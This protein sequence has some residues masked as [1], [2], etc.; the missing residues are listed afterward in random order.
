MSSYKKLY[1]SQYIEILDVTPPKFFKNTNHLYTGIKEPSPIFKLVKD[2]LL[3]QQIT[4]VQTVSKHRLA[5]PRITIINRLLLKPVSWLLSVRSHPE[6]IIPRRRS[7]RF[8]VYTERPP[9]PPWNFDS[10]EQEDREQV[11][12]THLRRSHH[13]E[14]PRSAVSYLRKTR[15]VMRLQLPRNTSY[16]LANKVWQSVK[17]TPHGNTVYTFPTRDHGFPR[18]LLLLRR[19]HNEHNRPHMPRD[20]LLSA[21]CPWNRI[22]TRPLGDVLLISRLLFLR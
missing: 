12:L 5:I 10:P 1:S 17:P 4:T 21:N 8:I 15:T 22:Q 2:S 20:T 7:S 16:P 14:I 13:D 19:A 6:W 18:S 3:G 9:R 11:P